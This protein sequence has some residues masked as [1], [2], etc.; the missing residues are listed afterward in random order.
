MKAVEGKASLVVAPSVPPPA[1]T[2]MMGG[3]VLAGLIPIGSEVEA[4]MDTGDL[5]LRTTIMSRA[6]PN[7]LSISLSKHLEIRMVGIRISLRVMANFA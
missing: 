3:N 2:P 7:F 4:S 1:G 5:F 6:Q